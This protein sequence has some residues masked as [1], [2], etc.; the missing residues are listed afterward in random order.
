MFYV[1]TLVVPS[2]IMISGYFL[3]KVKPKKFHEFIRLITKT[4]PFLYCYCFLMYY[5]EM[6]YTISG[7]V[8]YSILFF[9]LPGSIIV[10]IL[11]LYFRWKNKKTNV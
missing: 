3:S 10:L 7:W 6:H 11:H 1:Y 2:L 8:Y 5:L 9:L 4:L